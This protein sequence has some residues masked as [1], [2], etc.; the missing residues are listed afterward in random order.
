MIL[1]IIAIIAILMIIKEFKIIII[2]HRHIH[3]HH[4]PDIHDFILTIEST[5]SRYHNDNGDHDLT[6]S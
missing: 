4:N 6:I 5:I 2:Q 1:L 3:N